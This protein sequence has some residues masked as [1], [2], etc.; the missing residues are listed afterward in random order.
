MK[1]EKIIEQLNSEWDY[2]VRMVLYRML[3]AVEVLC[4]K[5]F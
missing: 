5:F 1:I 3:F 4:R 2:H